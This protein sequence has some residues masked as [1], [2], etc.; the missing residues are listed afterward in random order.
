MYINGL[1][2]ARD[3]K[4]FDRR[5]VALQRKW[6]EIEI[7]AHPTRDPFFHAWFLSNKAEVMK[8]TMIASVRTK[9][10]LGSPPGRY[11][12][13]RNESCCSSFFR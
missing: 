13:N 6:D 11:T 4:D 9:A 12:T 5:L 3:A 2:D 7:S 10:G 1:V 8:T